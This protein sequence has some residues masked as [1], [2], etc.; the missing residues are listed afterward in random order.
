MGGKPQGPKKGGGGNLRG[1]GVNLEIG[2]IYETSLLLNG[3]FSPTPEMKARDQAVQKRYR[4]QESVEWL[5]IYCTTH[6]D[7]FDEN[8]RF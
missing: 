4:N 7:S 2:L 8:P 1:G 5:Q 6:S 3:F